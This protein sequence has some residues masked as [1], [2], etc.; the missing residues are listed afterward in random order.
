MKVAIVAPHMIPCPPNG[1]GGIENF[2]TELAEGLGELGVDVTLFCHPDSTACVNREHVETIGGGSGAWSSLASF[3]YHQKVVYRLHEDAWDIVH[4]NSPIGI[5]AAQ[6]VVL[7]RD[8]IYFGTSPNG[9]D[10]CT[11]H[12][13]FSEEARNIYAED[14]LTNFVFVSDAQYKPYHPVLS[15]V[16]YRHVIHHGID[17][18]KIPEVRSAES[19]EGHLVHL[20]RIIRDKGTDNAVSICER[21]DVVLFVGGEMDSSVDPNGSY[22]M[23]TRKN[24]LNSR[25][26]HWLGKLSTGLVYNALNRCSGLLLPLQWEEPFG[27]I[28]IEAMACGAPVFTLNRGSAAEIVNTP[29]VGYVA[30]SIPELEEAVVSYADRRFTDYDPLQIREYARKRF[31]RSIMCTK[32]LELYKQIL[33]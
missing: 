13:P 2:C 28:M 19:R 12:H 14:L 27:L 4:F 11:V 32:Y 3:D 21:N 26:V 1:L 6:A 7:N 33:S 29:D 22:F 23:R 20:G 25:N 16:R 8:T 5:L 10:V 17:F 24:I 31:D 18:R 15:D 9:E 30:E